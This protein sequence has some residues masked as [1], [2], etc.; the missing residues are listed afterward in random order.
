MRKKVEDFR[1]AIAITI[2][3]SE[4]VPIDLIGF[5]A[6]AC[7][8][9]SIMLMTYLN[10]CGY[11]NITYVSGNRTPLDGGQTESH[12]FLKYQDSFIDITGSQFDDCEEQIIFRVSHPMHESFKLKDRGE[13][14][15]YKYSAE[16]S[17]NYVPIYEEIIAMLI[18]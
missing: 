1:R 16:G 3:T 4:H 5:P 7:E 6:G 2:Q 15:I 18:T 13:S 14:D 12:S 8:V 9:S 17:V 10:S 11:R